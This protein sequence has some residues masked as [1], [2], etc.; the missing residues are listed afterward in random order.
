MWQW[1]TD[2]RSPEQPHLVRFA[3]ILETDGGSIA[4]QHCDIVHP[5]DWKQPVTRECVMLHGVSEA[6]GAQ[7]GVDLPLVLG[8]I[9]GLIQ[10]AERIVAHSADF[11]L[12]VLHRGFQDMGLLP[13]PRLAALPVFDTMKK[14][15]PVVKAKLIGNGAWAWPKLEVA[16]MHFG[17]DPLPPPSEPIER[18]LAVVEAVRTVYHGLVHEGLAPRPG[19]RA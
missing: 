16:C 8:R 18:G 14:S 19:V 11:H 15:A 13:V 7:H 3:A 9:N 5:R 1:G 12:R 6:F 2:R 10:R 17:G 4:E